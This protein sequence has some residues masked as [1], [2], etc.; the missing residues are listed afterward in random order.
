MLNTKLLKWKTNFLI[1]EL[2]E[3]PKVSMGFY[4]LFTKKHIFFLKVEI[5]IMNLEPTV[6]LLLIQN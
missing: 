5:Y 2:R 4:P 3:I 6:F 1:S